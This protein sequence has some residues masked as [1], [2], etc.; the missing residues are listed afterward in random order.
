MATERSSYFGEV[1]LMKILTAV[2]FALNMGIAAA[3]LTGCDASPPTTMPGAIPHAQ[4]GGVRAHGKSWM[5]ASSSKA[6]LYFDDDTTNDTYV[7]EYPSG[8]KVGTLTGFHDPQGMCVD[9]KGDVYIT[10]PQFGLLFEYAH[11]GTEPMKIYERPGVSLN[12]C[13]VSASG[14]VAATGSNEVCI[15]RGGISAHSPTCIAGDES[16]GCS[17]LS[18]FGYDHDGNLIGIGMMDTISG[19]STTACMIP[20]GTTTMVKLSTSGIKFNFAARGTAWDGKYITLA[21][22]KGNGDVVQAAT[23]SGTTLTGVGREVQLD[24]QAFMPG[25]PFFFGKQNITAASTTRATSATIANPRY[26]KGAAD[27]WDY[28][29]GGKEPLLRVRAAR[30]SGGDAV[31]IAE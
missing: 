18:P 28:P 4:L 29:K 17:G 12:G 23:L 22:V 31:S 11:G 2:R 27:V 26:P 9:Q 24:D 21:G 13:S 7:Y 3:V 25:S 30:D 16:T 19:I 20:A 8:K 14:D 5:R 6:L 15:W 1:S 10:N